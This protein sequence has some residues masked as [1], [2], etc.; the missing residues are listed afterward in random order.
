[1]YVWMDDFIASV[2]K[3]AGIPGIVRVWCRVHPR[4]EQL[5][6][7]N[8]SKKAKPWSCCD[9]GVAGLE[10]CEAHVAV[11]I[12]IHSLGQWRCAR[13]HARVQCPSRKK[14]D[15]ITY[16]WSARP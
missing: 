3:R 5:V 16:K 14:S 1:M 7:E 15:I 8:R 9:P 10:L 12:R 4:A 2:L 11:P 6:I 13:A